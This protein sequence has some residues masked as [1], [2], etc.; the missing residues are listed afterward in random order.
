MKTLLGQ[1][2]RALVF[3][4]L[5]AEGSFTRAA[6]KLGCSKAHVSTQLSALEADF[7]VQLIHRTTRR[8]SLTEAGQLYLEFAKQVQEA[9]AEGER[10]VSATRSEVTGRLHITVPPSL[11]E[12]V[13]PELLL[14]FR[15]RYPNV[16]PIID[17]SLVRRDLTAD[18]FDVAFRSTHSLDNHLVAR[19]IGVVRETAVAAPSLLQAYAP[20]AEPEDLTHVPCLINSHFADGPH[21]LFL[22]EGGSASV[23]VSGPLIVNSYQAI[24]RF[25]L[26][27]LGAARLPRYMVDEDLIR[28]RLQVICDEWKIPAVPL[29]VVY[30]GQRH[31][32]LRTRIFVDFA[33]RWFEEPGRR[34]LFG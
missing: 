13:L 26:L 3:A 22:R 11:G 12:I 17:M 16:N 5:A 2:E 21:W 4:A 10:A 30:P 23:T 33:V 1:S 20:I 8:I 6:A 18:R 32:P 15:E 14:A 19:P 7:G 9:L 31:L 25:A 29:Y 27:G 28:G 34:K 24:R